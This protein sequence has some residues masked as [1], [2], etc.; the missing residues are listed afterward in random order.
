MT[1]KICLGFVF[2]LMTLNAFAYQLEVVPNGKKFRPGDLVSW[3]VDGDYYKYYNLKFKEGALPTLSDL[4]S[5]GILKSQLKYHSMNVFIEGLQL[6]ANCQTYAFNLGLSD[7]ITVHFQGN[8]QTKDYCFKKL[9]DDLL[10]NDR[11]IEVVHFYTRV[12]K[13]L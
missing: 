5:R 3:G 1:K 6:P 8:E 2:I 12:I 9:I 7:S 4:A 13:S 10:A 11:E